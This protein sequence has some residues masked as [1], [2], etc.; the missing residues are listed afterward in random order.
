MELLSTQRIV[1]SRQRLGSVSFLSTNVSTIKLY[2]L[3]VVVHYIARARKARASN[4]SKRRFKR[5]ALERSF[6]HRVQNLPLE[7]APQLL[8]SPTMGL[9][10][11]NVH[12]ENYVK[13]SKNQIR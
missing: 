6:F 8:S 7:W 2:T 10:N 9:N 4:R 5:G 1:A 12:H 11:F 3:V 13:S